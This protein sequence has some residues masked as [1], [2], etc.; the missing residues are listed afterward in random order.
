MYGP[1]QRPDMAFHRFI[2]ALLEGRPIVMY[3]DGTQT[4]DF[5]FVDDIVE[6]LVRAPKAP[7]GSVM[8][9]GGGNRVSLAEAIATL[10]TV[11]GLEA[12]IDRRPAEAGDVKDTLADVGRLAAA[13][14]YRPTTALCDGLGCEYA[15]IAGAAP[16]KCR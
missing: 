12:I 15:W 3:G 6:G 1:R 8:N 4:R 14:G 13:V 9:I 10:E 5:T 7:A 16:G 11:T 2:R